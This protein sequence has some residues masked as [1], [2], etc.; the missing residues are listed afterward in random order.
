MHPTLRLNSKGSDVAELQAALNQCPSGLRRLA[1]DGIFGIQTLARVQEFQR[2][3]HLIVDGIV[4]PN[5]WA[6]LEPPDPGDCEPSCGNGSPGNMA[7]LLLIQQQFIA[8]DP[9]PADS[10]FAVTSVRAS[11]NPSPPSSACRLFAASSMD[12]PGLR[13][14]FGGSIDYSTVYI[15]SVTGFADRPFTVAFES[16]G[17]TVQ[18]MNLGGWQPEKTVIHE[19]THVWQSQHHSDPQAFMRNCV[20]CQAV[21]VAQNSIEATQ[22]PALLWNPEFQGGSYPFSAYAYRLNKPFGAYGGEQIAQQ[23]E[24]NVRVMRSYVSGASQ[25]EVDPGNTAS[26]SNDSAVEDVRANGVYMDFDWP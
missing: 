17:R 14:V 12:T 22:N 24:K 23:V 16:R 10:G 3:N 6:A 2:D 15:R 11:A 1:T 19:M 21:A 18:V 20:K 25:R 5:T 7:S 13:Q 26:L 9:G 4:G 8:A